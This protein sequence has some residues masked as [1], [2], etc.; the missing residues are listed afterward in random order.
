MLNRVTTTNPNLYFGAKEPK[1]VQKKPIAEEAIES[2][3]VARKVN[4]H[5]KNTIT[6][7]ATLGLAGFLTPVIG[8]GFDMMSG[9]D[10][11]LVKLAQTVDT[12]AIKLD[13]LIAK[14]NI[15]QKINKILS[16]IERKLFKIENVEVF[17]R[18]F[19]AAGGLEGA[20]NTAKKV[21]L[22]ANDP[23]KVKIAER[24]LDSL[25]QINQLGS[26]G[27]SLGKLGL[28]MKK[29]T[30]GTVGIMNGIF[31]VM[32]INSVSKAKE[33][34]K[35]STLMEDVF[36]VWIGSLGGFKLSENF[37]RACHQLILEGKTAGVLPKIAKVV[38]K[39]PYKG[40]VV[41]MVGTMII[42]TGMQ[43]L[44]HLLF[45]K[46]TKEK[47]IQIDSI[48]SFNQW[49]NQLGIAPESK[50]INYTKILNTQHF[51]V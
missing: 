28:F 13:S 29:H 31:A 8:K 41:P 3:P 35:L 40:F 39:V 20:A 12:K 9:T 33:G 26:T 32:T 43:K 14:L 27:K 17:K 10:G 16:P 4:E 46:P 6:S 51:V 1:T 36:G 34:E 38:E 49:M 44:A 50:K 47:A 7:L 22:N 42:S 5:R 48:D 18:G 45:G 21:A 19:N 2:V 25:K 15:G 11:K 37:L 30:T 23:I 24:T